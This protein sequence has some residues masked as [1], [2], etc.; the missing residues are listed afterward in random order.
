MIAAPSSSIASVRRSAAS[1]PVKRPPSEKESGVTFR[2]PITRAPAFRPGRQSRGR[3]RQSSTKG[4]S[5]AEALIR[6][7]MTGEG[8]GGAIIVSIPAVFAKAK[9][10][11]THPYVFAGSARGSRSEDPRGAP[12]EN[13]LHAHARDLRRAGCAEGVSRGG[14][15]LRAAAGA[16]LPGVPPHDPTGEVSTDLMHEE[17]LHGRCGTWGRVC[18]CRSAPARRHRRGPPSG[19]A[20]CGRRNP[21]ALLRL[22][23]SKSLPHATQT[24]SEK[25][26]THLCAAHKVSGFIG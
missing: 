7:W 16:R 26:E 19:R 14:R 3:P 5:A 2:M 6:I 23:R 25:S 8:R 12:A 20:S 11:R 13:R 18:D 10:R 9:S 4:A 21:L 1:R 15:A 22:P 24:S 17:R